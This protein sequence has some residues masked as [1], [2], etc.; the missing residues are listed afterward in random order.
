MIGALGLYRVMQQVISSVSRLLCCSFFVNEYIYF[1]FIH[2]C[3][4]QFTKRT[5][6]RDRQMDRQKVY[7]S[8]TVTQSPKS[9]VFYPNL[10]DSQGSHAS[11]KVLEKHP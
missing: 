4:E 5:K 1:L 2:A 8:E 6:L 11:W 7:R 10:S 9:F 3:R